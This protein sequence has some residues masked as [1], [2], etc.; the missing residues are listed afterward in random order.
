[1]P[2]LF[3]IIPVGDDTVLNGVLEGQDTS[4]AL[5]FVTDVAVFLTHT[6]H[7]TLMSGATDNGWEDS[8]GCVIPSET[9]LAHTGSIVYNQCGNIVVTHS[10]GFVLGL[11]TSQELKAKG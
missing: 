6:H 2:D 9:G 3:H 4:L 7:D 5:G 10:A 8:T 1:M 11:L